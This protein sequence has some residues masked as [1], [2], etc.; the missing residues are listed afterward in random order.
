LGGET[1]G[2]KPCAKP[3]LKLRLAKPVPC[4]KEKA[5]LTAGSFYFPFG[6]KS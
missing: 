6:L 4:A 2:E 1:A 5:G 3:S